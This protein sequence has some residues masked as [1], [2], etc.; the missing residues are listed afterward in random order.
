M[1]ENTKITEHEEHEAHE[2]NESNNQTS[3][4]SCPSCWPVLRVLGSPTSRH[5]E[6][7]NADRVARRLLLEIVPDIPDGAVVARVDGGLRII[8]PAERGRLCSFTER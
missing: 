5:P 1:S 3:C 6:R 7:T 8:L 4:S 2:G